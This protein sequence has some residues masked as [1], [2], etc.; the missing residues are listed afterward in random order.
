MGILT[1]VAGAAVGASLQPWG[2][3]RLRKLRQA[4]RHRGTVDFRVS[5]SHAISLQ[6][7]HTTSRSSFL[8][9][10]SVLLSFH[11]TPQ[12]DL[13]ESLRNRPLHNGNLFTVTKPA[14]DGPT[15][16]EFHVDRCY[17]LLG[18]VTIL[19]QVW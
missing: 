12:I 14:G 3:S 9:G 2:M 16:T 4:F 17:R 8:R 5:A 18:R 6:I 10:R 7:G 11:R 13:E 19:L 1:F 15:F